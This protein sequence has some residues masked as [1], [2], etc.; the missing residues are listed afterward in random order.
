[1]S[2]STRSM[3]VPSVVAAVTQSVPVSQRRIAPPLYGLP[4]E[5]TS[6]TRER[7]IAGKRKVSGGKSRR[8]VEEDLPRPTPAHKNRPLTL[9]GMLTVDGR[10]VTVSMSA[11]CPSVTAG[12]GYLDRATC[13]DAHSV[14]VHFDRVA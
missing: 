12:F 7:M 1:M 5:T 4:R 13:P 14:R 10:N 11:R 9:T 3:G 6:S 2:G 8:P